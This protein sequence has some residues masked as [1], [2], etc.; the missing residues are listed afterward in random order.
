V[1]IAPALVI[2]ALVGLCHSLDLFLG[3]VRGVLEIF[4]AVALVQQLFRD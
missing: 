3:A 1:V 2:L 4:R